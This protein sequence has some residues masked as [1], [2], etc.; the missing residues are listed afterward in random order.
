MYNEVTGRFE[1]WEVI[2]KNYDL[3]MRAHWRADMSENMKRVLLRAVRIAAFGGASMGL[4]FLV[5]HSLDLVGNPI[6]VPL[7][8]A[9]LAA[10]DKFVRDAL[11]KEQ[12]D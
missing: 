11:A 3:A 9:I 1:T 8:T 2:L 5:G 7:A 10:V 6:F 12:T 4:Q